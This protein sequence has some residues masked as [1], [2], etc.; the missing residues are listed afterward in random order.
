MI[1]YS[2]QVSRQLRNDNAL[3]ESFLEQVE[4]DSNIDWRIVSHFGGEWSKFNYFSEQEIQQVGDDYFDIVKPEML[5]KQTVALDVGCGSGRW[6]KYVADKA[7]FVEAVDPSD[8]IFAASKLLENCP[9]VR[10]TQAAVSQLPFPDNSF[11]FVF[12]LGVLH[13]VPDTEKAIADCVKK[14]KKGGY[15][16]V[17]L[18]Y[19]LDNR[20]FLY[21]TFFHLSNGIRKVIS[22][23][24]QG[25][26]QAL[27]D[28]I[29]FTVYLPFVTIARFVKWL[30]PNSRLYKYIPLYYYHDKSLNIIR[31]DALDRFG[32]PLEL[33]FSKNEIR[34]MMENCGL[35][36]IVFSEKEPLW[37]AAGRKP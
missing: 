28:V 35:S 4:N 10:I 24:P 13:C 18:Y 20:G 31:N 7:R 17:Y 5:N 9:N 29:A 27:C 30:S 1:N 8:A 14:L 6:S 23:L 2:L 26:K 11:D 34:K 22:V 19:A 33:R 3:I 25:L 16:L 12:S 36:D 37:H 32:T 15:F 21:K